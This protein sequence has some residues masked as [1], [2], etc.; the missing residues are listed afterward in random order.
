M[1]QTK[2]LIFHVW[3]ISYVFTEPESLT[4]ELKSLQLHLCIPI[5]LRQIGITQML[6]RQSDFVSFALLTFT[7][8]GFGIWSF[9]TCFVL[10]CIHQSLDTSCHQ[11]LALVA[12]MN[13][14]NFTVL[15]T[16]LIILL[17]WLLTQCWPL[18]TE[19]QTTQFPIAEF[20][21]KLEFGWCFH[22]QQWE[23]HNCREKFVKFSAENW[24]L[25][26][27]VGVCYLF[28]GHLFTD[29]LAR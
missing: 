4:W 5:D 19:M 3:V 8:N 14:V 13:W 25:A 16:Q 18:I 29:C 24:S 12:S 10:V 28:L 17:N 6:D 11:C 22:S 21:C 15:Y 9:E 2:T 1:L 7:L 27:V 23:F 26:G 20:H